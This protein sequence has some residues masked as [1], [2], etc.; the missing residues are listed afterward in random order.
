[1]PLPGSGMGMLIGMGINVKI[2]VL[3]ETTQRRW[4]NRSVA[5]KRLCATIAAQLD[6]GP[7]KVASP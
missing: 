1:M 7:V 6:Y 4:A 3:I 2:A 5:V